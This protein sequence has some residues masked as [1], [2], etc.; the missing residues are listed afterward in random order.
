[1]LKITIK[2]KD[3]MAM[4]GMMGKPS[5]KEG[6]GKGDEGKNA[7]EQMLVTAE[8]KAMIEKMRG[9]HEMGEEKEEGEYA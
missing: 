7:M 1:M 3:P 5:K 9:S 4:M 6:M 2:E 8:E